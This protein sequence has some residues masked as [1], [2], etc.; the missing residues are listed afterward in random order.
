MSDARARETV[1]CRPALPAQQHVCPHSRSIPDSGQTLTLA[2]AALR[3]LSSFMVL[4]AI[5]VSG[6]SS[7]KSSTTTRSLPTK[8]C[9]IPD[10]GGSS[11]P[12]D[13]GYNDVD[14]VRFREGGGS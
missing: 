7:R 8:A 5:S 14:G 4:D 12:C 2:L 6:R 13:L 9:S 11:P 3:P 1:K 10:E